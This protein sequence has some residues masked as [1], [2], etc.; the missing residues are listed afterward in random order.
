MN[1][2]LDDWLAKN[3]R[4]FRN[5]SRDWPHGGGGYKTGNWGGGGGGHVKFYPYEKEGGE[6]SLNHAKRGAQ[7]MLGVVFMR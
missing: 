3:N 6:K 7:K 2:Y 1:P 4:I 5:L